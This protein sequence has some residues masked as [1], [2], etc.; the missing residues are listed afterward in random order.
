[1]VWLQQVPQPAMISST[2]DD[3]DKYDEGWDFFV[4]T[5]SFVDVWDKLDE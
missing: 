2:Q 3:K 5:L 4:D 1:M